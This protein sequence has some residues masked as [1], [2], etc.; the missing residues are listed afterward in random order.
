MTAVPGTPNLDADQQAVLALPAGASAVV[1]GAPGSGRTTTAVALVADRIRRGLLGPDEVL[2]LAPRRTQASRL[3]DRLLLA[4]GRPVSAP[5]ART[6]ASLAFDIARRDAAED[7]RDT[8][9]L[10]SG[11]EQDRLIAQLLPESETEWPERLGQEVRET[12]VFRGELREL[13]ARCTERDLDPAALEDLGLELRRDEWRAAARF[14]REYLEV[15]PAVEP[16]AFD[17]AE[18]VALATA[19]VLRDRPGALAGSLRLVVVDD[20]QD[21]VSYTH[22]TLPTNRE[23]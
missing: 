23:V 20:M 2:L 12:R 15:L 7:G 17:S 16:D 22:L 11:G 4:V 9:V 14:W 1:L 18:L 10:L 5:L 13:F 19:A 8:P 21:P 3:R 6:A